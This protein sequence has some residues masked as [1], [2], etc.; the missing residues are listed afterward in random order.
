[1][2]WRGARRCC[3]SCWAALTKA[4]KH[5]MWHVAVAREAVARGAMPLAGTHAQPALIEHPCT[6]GLQSTRHG[7]SHPSTV[8][9]AITST[10]AKGEEYTLLPG[11]VFLCFTHFA[12]ALRLWLQ[13]PGGKGVSC[14]LLQN[15]LP[16]L[17]LLTDPLSHC[18][19]MPPFLRTVLP[20]A[21]ASTATSTACS[22]TAAPCASATES[23]L[24]PQ[25]RH[26]PPKKGVLLTCFCRQ[27]PA[28]CHAAGFSPSLL[29]PLPDVASLQIYP[30]ADGACRRKGGFR[31][32][33]GLG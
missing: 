25:C 9:L 21:T 24:D 2:T 29:G 12:A 4:R 8:T 13:D 6:I 5:V 1:M 17:F 18:M 15:L 3:V 19:L 28:V 33:V 11:P 10:W 7:S 32:A 22:W 20:S 31:A 16:S 27:L 30:G 23:C 26:D 14:K